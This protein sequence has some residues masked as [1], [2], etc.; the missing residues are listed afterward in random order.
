ML[1]NNVDYLVYGLWNKK[2]SK[3]GRVSFKQRN[4]ET[5]LK[6]Y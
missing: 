1:T 3:M 2:L 6:I 4:T 5:T